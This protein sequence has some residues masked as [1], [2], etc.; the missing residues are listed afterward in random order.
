MEIQLAPCQNVSEV[1]EQLQAVVDCQGAIAQSL[2]AHASPSMR[3]RLLI[4]ESALY[5]YTIKVQVIHP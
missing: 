1:L 4:D 3:A 5:G 2:R